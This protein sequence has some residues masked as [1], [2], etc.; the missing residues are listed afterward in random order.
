M[1]SIACPTINACLKALADT[2]LTL[3]HLHTLER[4]FLD[5]FKDFSAPVI[6]YSVK[7]SG[8]PVAEVRKVY[9]QAIAGGVDEVD[10]DKLTT[11]EIRKQWTLAREQA[12][13]K[14]IITPGCSVPDASTAAELARMP[15]GGWGEGGM[16][17]CGRFDVSVVASMIVCSRFT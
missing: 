4:P 6:N 17:H 10:F 14:Y 12:G 13:S 3:L 5:Q 9:S 16:Q 7:T 11:E 2:K 1:R 8:I 15:G